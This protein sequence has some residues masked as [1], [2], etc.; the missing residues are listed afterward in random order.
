MIWLTVVLKDFTVDEVPEHGVTPAHIAPTRSSR[1]GGFA[2][3]A[4]PTVEVS[5]VT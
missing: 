1:S 5:E 4:D 3:V 2:D